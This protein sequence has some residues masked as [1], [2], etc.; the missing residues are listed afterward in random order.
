MK[1]TVEVWDRQL[2]T[3]LNEGSEGTAVT[4]E[5]LEVLKT[6]DTQKVAARL[7]N[8]EGSQLTNEHAERL[9]AAQEQLARREVA[10]ARKPGKLEADEERVK[11]HA[12]GWVVTVLDEG[13]RPSERKVLRFDSEAAALAEAKLYKRALVYAVAPGPRQVLIW[14]TRS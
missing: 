1:F 6:L 2:R 11:H 10:R 9:L 14:P 7:I 3:W 5:L 8:D 13:A 12:T 4:P